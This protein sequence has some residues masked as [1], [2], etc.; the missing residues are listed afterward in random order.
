M[1]NKKN[2]VDLIMTSPEFKEI[3]REMEVLVELAIA[4]N[5]RRR[6]KDWSQQK[7]A[8]EVGTTQAIISKIENAD[9]NIGLDLLQRLARSLG[10]VLQFG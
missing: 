6:L 2:G 5:E 7:L 1:N 8:E 10:V 3:S 4:V 9:I